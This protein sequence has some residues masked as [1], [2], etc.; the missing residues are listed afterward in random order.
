MKEKGVILPIFSL[1]S[2]YGIGDFGNEAYEF[3]DILSENNINYWQILPINACDKLPYAP[4]SYYALDENYLSLDKL[5]E[6]GLIKNPK[7]RDSGNRVVYDNFKVEYYKEAVNNFNENAEYGKFIELKEINEYAEYMSTVSSESKKYYLVVQYMLYNQ[8][9]DIMKY[10]HSKNV[11]IIGDM[12]MYPAF[13]SVETKCHPEYF[14]MNDGKFEFEAGT[15][16]DSFSSTG[17]RWGIPVY[18][19]KNI[20]KDKYEYLV[21]RTSYYLKLF[22][23]IRIDHFIGYDHFY[24][25]PIGKFEEKGFYEDGVSYGFFDELFKNKHIKVEDLI[26]EDLGNLREETIK[27]KERYGFMGQKMLQSTTDLE[28]FFNVKNDTDVEENVMLLPGNHDCRTLNSWYKL[29][30]DEDKKKLQ[31]CLKKYNCYYNEDIN[32]GIIKY[33]FSSNAKIVMVTI[34]DILGLD[35]T[36]RI[37]VP[38]VN[39]AKNWSWK[40]TDFSTFKEKIKN[41]K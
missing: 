14:Q 6:Q 30:S 31:N 24:K 12:P 11:K 22:D 41:F 2:K 16:P 38:G 29:L 9:M 5:K 21:K 33:C 13:N 25:I 15:P 26:V 37:N 34:Q 7:A 20:K 8:W 3:I 32:I 23:K 27:L 35:D 1:P 10:A 4:L 17:Q 39:L 36:A 18:N 40:L 28:N 19:V